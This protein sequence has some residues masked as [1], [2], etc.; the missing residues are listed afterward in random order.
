[1]LESQEIGM[2]FLVYVTAN[3][4]EETALALFN[5]LMVSDPWPNS[6]EENDRLVDFA[7]LVAKKFNY[8]SWVE[9]YHK[10]GKKAKRA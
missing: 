5:L 3:V 1:M 4:T 8:D 10:I 9:A 2:V 7:N 6:N